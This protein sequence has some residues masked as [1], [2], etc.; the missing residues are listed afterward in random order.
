MSS[1]IDVLYIVGD[2]SLYN[3][4]ELKYSLRSLEENCWDVRD[5]YIAG[6]CPDFI[7]KGKV[8]WCDVQDVS[9]PRFNHWWKVHNTFKKHKEMTKDVVLMYD[10]IFMTKQVSLEHYPYYYSGELYARTEINR[11]HLAKQKSKVFL[12]TI[13]KPILDFENHC[14]IRYN[15]SKFL[16]MEDI[17]SGLKDDVV[18]LSVRS[19]YANQYS[20]PKEMVMQ[21][22]L[23]IREPVQNIE[24][25]IKNH[26]YFSISA[27]QLKGEVLRW[28]QE[29]YKHKSKWEK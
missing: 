27:D 11:Y 19:V 23:K 25:V 10:D 9:N 14:P 7:D 21:T 22:D 13:G 5:V 8:I 3:N 6:Y 29:R 2:G 20:K 12:E 28:L 17:F 26:D 16:K 24:K 15:R 1:M 4:E 18:R